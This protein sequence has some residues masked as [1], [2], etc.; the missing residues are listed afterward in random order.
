MPIQDFTSQFNDQTKDQMG[1][2]LP[3]VI[4]VFEDRTFSF[5]VKKPP[6]ST[7]VKSKLNLKKGS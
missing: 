7:L 2:K 4:T 3:V 5:V 1:V 6:M